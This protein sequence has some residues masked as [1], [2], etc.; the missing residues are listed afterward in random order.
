[1]KKQIILGLS[2]LAT[3]LIQ[4]QGPA[5]YLHFNVGGGLHNLS[6][7]MPNGSQ[8]GKFGYTI[9]GAYSYFF[10][11]NWG[12]QAGLGI[13]S[14]GATSK[15]NYFTT[16]PAVDSEGD[17]F[18][19]RT[20]Y[21]NWEEN[22]N[23][24]YIEIPVAAQYRYTINEKFGLIGSLG[25]KMAL[26][27]YAKY[28]TIGGQ[29]RTTGYYELWNVE[30]YDLPEQGLSTI[31]NSFTDRISLNPVFTGL[32]DVG[33][34]YKLSNKLELYAG[35]YF[36]YGFNKTKTPDTKVIYQQ[37]GVYNGMFA[38]NQVQNVKPI[39]FGL[40]VGVYLQLGK[41]KLTVKTEPTLPIVTP[42]PEVPKDT[43]V[44][45]EQTPKK[46]EEPI[47]EKKAPLIV[48]DPKPVANTVEP[49]DSFKTAKAL[50]SSLVIRF[51]ENSTQPISKVN[52]EKFKTI[53]NYLKSNPKARLQIIGHTSNTGS[54]RNNIKV[55]TQRALEIQN[56]LI[57][58]GAPKAQ[59]ITLS[60]AYDDPLVPNTTAA[61]R[62]KNRRVEFELTKK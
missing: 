18:E 56:K 57:K 52:N 34:L 27:V 40:K 61:N 2:L 9:N 20:Q 36:N 60:K 19:S 51:D 35:V 29:I 32:A 55:G 49:T 30:L 21:S 8:N 16:A 41:Q 1:M 7:T 42:T 46:V 39:S 28:K 58:L 48:E 22:Q 37:N 24:L 14:F 44:V 62:A 6:Y 50:A 43:V 25:A 54:R 31:T 33:G 26:P 15:L 17:A 5:Q 4:A 13:Q 23:A 47:V 53:I 3:V 38:S 12:V 45:I 10:T 11:P 59:L